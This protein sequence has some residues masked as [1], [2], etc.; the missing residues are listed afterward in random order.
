MLA[1]TLVTTWMRCAAET[2]QPCSAAKQT[3]ETEG[4]QSSGNAT[5]STVN[6]PKTASAHHAARTSQGA[7]LVPTATAVPTAASR[8]PDARSPP[9]KIQR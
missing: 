3:A 8:I 6:N 5:S 2:V 9:A 1:T 7:R 4:P